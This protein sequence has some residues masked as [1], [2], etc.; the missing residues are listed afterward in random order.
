[1]TNPAI[2]DTLE[3]NGEKYIL[4]DV[5][6]HF[7]SYDVYNQDGD[8]MGSKTMTVAKWIFLADN[9]YLQKD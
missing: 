8:L 4:F 6:D 9:G 5:D 7:A 2:G 1:M 3:V